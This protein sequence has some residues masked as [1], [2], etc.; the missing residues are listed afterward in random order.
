MRTLIVNSKKLGNCTIMYDD[1]DHELISQYKKWH[2]CYGGKTI[3][4]RR[5]SG[6]KGHKITFMHRLIMGVTDPNILVDHKNRNGLDNRRCN[7]RIATKSQ[8]AYNK[9]KQKN[10][11]SG[12]KGVTKSTQHGNLRFL[13]RIWVDGK[14]LHLG[15]FMVAIE[16]AK[17]YNKAAIKF[18]GE[19]ACIN[20]IVE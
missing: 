6:S 16:A 18:H 11:T 15:T 12:F 3:Y 17:C 8:N 14:M 20:E 2:P 1:A 19:F 10:N 13:A 9:T 4:V 7:L 5:G